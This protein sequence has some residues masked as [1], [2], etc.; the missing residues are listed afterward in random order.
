M[1]MEFS[2]GNDEHVLELDRGGYYATGRMYA[3][4]LNCSFLNGS[5]LFFVNLTSINQRV[6]SPRKV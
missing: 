1:G 3:M 4:P 6:L 5:F 2:L